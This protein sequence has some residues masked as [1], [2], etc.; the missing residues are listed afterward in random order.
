MVT[1]ADIVRLDA[2]AVR[3]SVQVVS[4]AGSADLVRST[5]CAGWTLVDLLAHMTA[6]H[7]GFAAAAAGD[8]ADL[9]RWQTGAP[10]ADPVGEYA[11]AAAQVVAAFGAPG[12]LDRE[13]ALPEVSPQLRFPAEQAIGF[14]LVDYVV[15]GWDVARALGLRYD[16]EPEL[17]AAALPIAR[18]VP[19]GQNRRRPGA[20][21]APR[22]TVTRGGLLEQIVA[23]LGRRP[24]WPA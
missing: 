15:H 24:G 4:R 18:S 17:L 8:G 13:F 23:L 6:Q 1:A 3:A 5:P 12:M 19:D 21:F 20:S 14:H 9:V 2:S 16:L 11:T 7:H 22:V 10:A